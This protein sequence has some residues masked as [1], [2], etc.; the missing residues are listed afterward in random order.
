MPSPENQSVEIPA[1]PLKPPPLVILAVATPAV[2][3]LH[4]AVAAPGQ[5]LTLLAAATPE[6]AASQL[7]LVQ[8]GRLQPH[9]AVQCLSVTDHAHSRSWLAEMVLSDNRCCLAVPL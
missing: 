6:V 1:A 5:V 2:A 7:Q 9:K 4:L 3:T 8:V